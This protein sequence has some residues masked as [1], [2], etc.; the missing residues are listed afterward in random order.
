MILI[1][2]F[3]K[4]SMWRCYVAMKTVRNVIQVIVYAAAAHDDHVKGDGNN[5]EISVP[6]G[7]AILNSL[8]ECKG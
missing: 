8:L 2:Q 7:M 4:Q 3:E 5:D 1:I 6:D